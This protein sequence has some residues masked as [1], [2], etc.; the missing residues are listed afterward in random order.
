M[1]LSSEDVERLERAG[2]DKQKFTR[3]DKHGFAKLK[4]HRGFCFFYDAEKCRCKIYKQR[5]SGC[6]IY[7]VIYSE[8]EGI[9]VDDLCP[10]KN[11]VSK[12]ELKRKGKKVV[13]LLQRI[14]AE[15]TS[16]R[17]TTREGRVC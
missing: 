5:P 10:N 6:R 13:E 9:I 1:L 8:R 7:P 4:N 16:N 3:Y 2:Y 12:S 17:N 14:D 15:A 11:T